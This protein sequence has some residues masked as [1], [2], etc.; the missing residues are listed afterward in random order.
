LLLDTDKQDRDRH[1]NVMV[2]RRSV[3]A[4]NPEHE[5]TASSN[6]FDW[7]TEDGFR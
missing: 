2:Y 3:R 1:K 5:A 7:S 6:G 4:H